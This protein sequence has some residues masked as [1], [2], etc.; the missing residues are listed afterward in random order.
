VN[1]LRHQMTLPSLLRY[2]VWRRIGSHAP[3]RVQLRYGPRLELRP[4]PFGDP[5]GAHE[6]FVRDVYQCPDP[7]ALSSVKNI[8]DI[9]ANIG[10][11]CIYWA[12][13]FKEAKI[14]AF[15]PHP[16]HIQI[17]KRHAQLNHL[18]NRLTLIEAAA[19]PEPGEA[20]LSDASLC[21][22]LVNPNDEQSGVRVPIVDVFR[23]LDNQSIDLPKIDVEGYEFAILGDSRMSSISAAAIVI[24]W[25]NTAAVP[26]GKSWCKL[27]PERGR[28]PGGRRQRRAS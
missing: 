19:G 2:G 9:G 21:S 6:I 23:I 1:Y 3:V 20:V 8:V 25:H 28:V 14:L 17:L 18:E 10:L 5:F 22:S 13:N 7:A 24:E 16:T 27:T 11:S 12:H 26:D 15:E 4:A